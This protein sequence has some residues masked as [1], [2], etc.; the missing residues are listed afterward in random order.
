MSLMTADRA[1]VSV[2][3]VV[4]IWMAIALIITTGLMIIG[5]HVVGAT[6]DER[7]HAVMLETYFKTGWYASPDW[8][9]DGQPTAKLGDWPYFVYAPVSA[10]LLHIPAAIF[11]AEPWGGFSDTAAAY[12]ARHVGTAIIALL[13]VAAAGLTLRLLTRSWRWALVG[14]ASLASIP[15]W[16]GHGIFNGK[17]L[18]VGTGYALVTMGLVIILLPRSTGVTSLRIL[19]WVSVVGGLVLSIG[20]R[21]ASGLPMVMTIFATAALLAMVAW[22]ASSENHSW[23]VPGRRLLDLVCAS[24]LAYLILLL[25]YPRGFIEPFRMAKETL[26]ISGR[27]PVMDPVLTNG[28]LL[29]QPVPWYYLPVWFGAQL[30]ILTIAG[31]SLFFFIY[32]YEWTALARRDRR[33]AQSC[34]HLVAVLP[35]VLQALLLPTLAV[36]FQSTIY[37]A[38]RQFLFVVPALAILA[39]LAVRALA[40]W[41]SQRRRL[42][43]TAYWTVISAGIA[44]PVL[45]QIQLFPYSYTY[46]NEAAQVRPIDGNWA[47]DYWRASSQELTMRIPPTGPESCS[48]IKKGALSP[49][50]Q[51]SPFTPFW[52]LRGLKA[53]PGILSEGEYWLARENAGAVHMPEN[54]E[55]HDVISRNLAFQKITIAQV[56]RCSE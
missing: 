52:E 55:V 53:K 44:V 24:V 4:A 40:Q 20:T 50:S 39:A 6:W 54:C 13:G 37:N 45:A 9:V 56:L 36:V 38:T 27:F 16:M 43:E 23:P 10:L 29:E 15:M 35:I 14:A 32:L 17:D 8:L 1:R 11:G 18:P 49:C 21:P 28:V 5:T 51:Q 41:F 31:A 12:A 46:F 30:P 42:Y 25:I 48:P 26:A 7:I 34:A 2:P 22:R 19:S 33:L 47:T 3:L